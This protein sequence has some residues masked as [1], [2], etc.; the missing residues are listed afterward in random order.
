MYIKYIATDS[1]GKSQIVCTD[2]EWWIFH[3]KTCV[4][5]HIVDYAR[6]KVKFKD[7]NGKVITDPQMSTLATKFFQSIK[8]K[9]KDLIIE[10]GTKL[11]DH[12]GEHLNDLIEILDIKSSVDNGADGSKTEFYHDF[13]KNI[14]SK[15]I[16]E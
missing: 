14:C 12:I 3:H 1:E 5:D 8:D 15:T 7:P 11:N 4:G 9:N 13:V 6:R 16:F 10:Y 2:T